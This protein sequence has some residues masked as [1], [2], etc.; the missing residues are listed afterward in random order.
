MP[1]DSG[2]PPPSSTL[3]LR[4]SILEREFEKLEQQM[5][6]YLEMREQVAVLRAEFQGFVV[7]INDRL[8]HLEI[9]LGE[10]ISDYNEDVKG[11]RKVMIGAAV[12]VMIAAVTFAITSL[13]VFGG[14]G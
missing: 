12:T 11:L 1:P 7:A 8:N 14:P 9:N 2:Q 6:R 5:E 3:N 4:V 10:D 13:A